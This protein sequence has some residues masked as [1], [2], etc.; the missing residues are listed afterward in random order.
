MEAIIFLVIFALGIWLA[1]CIWLAY[2]LIDSSGAKQFG[3]GV[4]VAKKSTEAHWQLMNVAQGDGKGNA[5][6]WIYFPS[7]YV[8]RIQIAHTTASKLVSAEVYESVEEGDG[9]SVEYSQ[10]RLSKDRAISF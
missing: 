10:G 1:Y 5:L 8:L 7:S 3:H 9:I 4:V 2:W 6:Q